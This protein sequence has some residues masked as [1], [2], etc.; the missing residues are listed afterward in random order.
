MKRCL[1]ALA[2]LGSFAAFPCPTGSHGHMGAGDA[3]FAFGFHISPI[4]GFGLEIGR[5]HHCVE[6]IVVAAVPQVEVE[7]EYVAPPIIAAPPP[8]YVAPTPPPMIPYCCQAA[9]QPPPPPMVVAPPVV[10]QQAPAP[11]PVDREPAVTIKFM[12]VG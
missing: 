9:P 8:V 1:L 11:A 4:F 2:L 3:A 5:V 12:P 10:V 7:P 6:P